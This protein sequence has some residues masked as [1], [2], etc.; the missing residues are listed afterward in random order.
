MYT[1][2][3]PPLVLKESGVQSDRKIV[4]P[5]S[6]PAMSGM[7]YSSQVSVITVIK[8][9]IRLLTLASSCPFCLL[10]RGVCEKDAGNQLQLA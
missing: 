1:H 3:L 4:H 2:T 9:S 8:L 10:A 6:S 5:A 7:F